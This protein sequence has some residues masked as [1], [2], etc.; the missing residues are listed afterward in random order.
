[1]KIVCLDGHTLNPGD[2]PWDGVAQLG[3]FTVYDRTPGDKIIER[4]GDADIILTNKTPLSAESLDQ[5]PGLKYIAVLATGFN[6]VN[7]EAARDRNI[8]VSN[9]PIYGTD[10]VAQFVFALLL[11][12]CHSVADHSRS[13]KEGKWQRSKDFCYWDHP[14]TE[15]KDKTM[16]IIGFGRIG[17]KTG[18]IARAFGMN[19][20]AADT[21]R[22]NPPA[23]D[24]QWRKIE[25]IF[26]E[27]DTIS[28]HCPQ[29]EENTG[30]VNE[31]L[32]GKMKP[33]AFLINTA[34]GGLINEAHL[35][36]A[37]NDRTIA[38]AAC[39]VVSVE[40]IKPDN[41]LLSAPNIILTPHIAWATLE[42]RKRL[43]ATT[44]ENVASFIKGE[45]VNVV[46]GVS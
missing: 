10:S 34:R 33:S 8:P 37:L 18:E 1:M 44:V 25:E 30:M 41:P 9:V 28:L 14:L 43:M 23:Y 13:I 3:D 16:G 27:A 35:A 11:D 38:G 6:V 29:T 22:E 40:P 21:Y 15:L 24:F 39:D 7:V 19:V 4:A 26:K 12:L 32:L 31:T 42:A 45:P 2:N 20:I 5:L 46:N 17:Q 36:K